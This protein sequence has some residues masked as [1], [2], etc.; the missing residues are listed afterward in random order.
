MDKP[1]LTA[2]ELMFR[3]RLRGLYNLYKRKDNIISFENWL[4]KYK[5]IDG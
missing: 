1:K 2:D 4:R 3:A 5:Y